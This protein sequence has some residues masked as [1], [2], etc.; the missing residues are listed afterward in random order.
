MAD[1]NLICYQSTEA[2]A[3]DLRCAFL[4]IVAVNIKDKTI[5]AV[6][7]QGLFKL[8]GDPNMLQQLDQLLEN[9]IHQERMKLTGTTYQPCY[10]IDILSTFVNQL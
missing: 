6:K 5:Q 7:T 8:K 4:G 3:A 1:L 9:F 2:L 10:E